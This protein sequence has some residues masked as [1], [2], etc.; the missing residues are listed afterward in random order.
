MNKIRYE[1]SIIKC[2]REHN[3]IQHF[4]LPLKSKTFLHSVCKWIA[5]FFH[6]LNKFFNEI[7]KSIFLSIH[8]ISINK[9]ICSTENPLQRNLKQSLMLGIFCSNVLFEALWLLWAFKLKSL[10]LCPCIIFIKWQC[11]A[12]VV[13]HIHTTFV[14]T[15]TIVIF[16][17]FTIAEVD[18]AYSEQLHI[19]KGKR[20]LKLRHPTLNSK[21]GVFCFNLWNRDDIGNI[22]TVLDNGNRRN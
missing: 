18:V 22:L 16:I 1:L 4:S 17:F 5:Y 14:H 7:L 12:A 21:A 9:S 8:K 2:T 15:C 19:L 10:S 13:A 11:L 20:S 6:T 3:K